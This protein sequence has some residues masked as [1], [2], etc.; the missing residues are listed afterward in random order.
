MISETFTGANVAAPSSWVEPTAPSGVHQR[1][2][3]HR[4]HRRGQSTA[5]DPRLCEPRRGLSGRR[6]PASDRSPTQPSGRGHD[7]ERPGLEWPRRHLRELSMGRQRCGRDRLRPGRRGSLES[8]G[9]NGHRTAGG[10]LGYASGHAAGAQGLAYGYLGVGLDAY[11][12]YSN[13]LED[14]SGCTDPSWDSGQNPASGRRAGPGQRG[15]RLLRPE[16]LGRRRRFPVAPWEHSGRVRGARRGGHQHHERPG[17]HDRQRVHRCQRPQ[18]GLRSGLDADRRLTGELHRRAP[19]RGERRHSEP[20]GGLYPSG[21]VNPSTGVPYQLGFGW[22][23]STG[24]VDDNHEISN[25][26]VSTL[27]PVPVLTAAISDSENGRLQVPGTVNYTVTGG[28]ATGSNESDPISMTTTL[29]SWGHPGHGSRDR[30]VVHDRRTGRHLHLHG[31]GRQ[32]GRRCRRSRCPQQW[33]K[34]PLPRPVPSAPR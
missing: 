4:R 5:A 18:R 22:V 13:P 30:L 23:G 33:P 9:A 16:Q 29:P 32:R 24:A 7:V 2:L 21:W 11:G 27:Q 14:G 26:V 3:S 19:D 34:P 28:V 15:R 17:Q 8:G 25:V 6:C 12:N 10:A 1:R 20:T 31:V